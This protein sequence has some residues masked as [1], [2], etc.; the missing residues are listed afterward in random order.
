MFSSPIPD[1]KTLKTR[2]TDALEIVK[3]IFKNEERDRLDILR[4]KKGAH[5]EKHEHSLKKRTFQL[6]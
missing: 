4:E 6:M 1:I 3:K 5:V 2:T